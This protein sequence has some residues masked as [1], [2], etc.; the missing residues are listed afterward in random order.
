MTR[1][2][3]KKIIQQ[4]II[5]KTSLEDAF[6]SAGYSYNIVV[7]KHWVEIAYILKSMIQQNL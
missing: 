4:S 3:L 6:E 1:N 2:Q 5:N 7:R